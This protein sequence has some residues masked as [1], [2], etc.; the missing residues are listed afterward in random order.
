MSNSMNTRHAQL[1][2]IN[3]DANRMT[4]N[5]VVKIFISTSG[6][7]QALI[8]RTNDH[9]PIQPLPVRNKLLRR[10]FSALGEVLVEMRRFATGTS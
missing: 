3:L 8:T 9:T 10:E 4:D 5:H 1:D 6:R 2:D 7:Q